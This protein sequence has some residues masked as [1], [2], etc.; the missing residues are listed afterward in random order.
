MLFVSTLVI[1]LLLSLSIAST[2]STSTVGRGENGG[3]TCAA[4]A[5]LVGLAEQLTEI[6]NE[7]IADSLAR[8]CSYLPFGFQE[9][10]KGLVEE[11]GPGI[12]ALIEKKET[13]DIACYGVGLCKHDTPQMCH[14]FPLPGVHSMQDQK[15]RILSAIK[16]AEGAKGRPFISIS[17][18]LCNIKILKPICDL[19]E[20]FSDKHDPLFDID[21]DLFSDVDSFR[22]TSW[23]GKDCN[24]AN[25][26][27]Y[28]GRRST[29]DPIYDSNCNGIFGI[30]PETSKTYEDQWCNGTSQLGVV[31]LGDSAGAHFHIPPEYLISKDLNVETFS[32]L[33]FILENEFDWPMLSMTTGY[34]NTS[35]WK[36]SISGP[37]DS[38]YLRFLQRNR[39]NHRDYQNIAVN[40]ARSSSMNRTIMRSLSRWQNLDYPVFII[41]ELIG[42]DVCSGHQDTSHMTTAQ[43]MHDNYL[44][45]FNYMDTVLPKESV[46]FA[47]GLVDGRILYDSLHNRIHPIGSLRG[48]VTYAQLYNYLNCL[49]ISPCF[50]WMNSN[51]TWR[52]ITTERAMEL[53][54]V[55]KDLISN[56]TT[57]KNIKVHYM[58]FPT[59]EVFDRWQA[60]GGKMW[61]L[62]EPVDG[63]HPNQQSNA[64]TAAVVWENLNKLYPEVI[65][66]IN[67]FNDLIVKKFGD[68]GGY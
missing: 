25:A 67:P 11:F 36:K 28:P 37:T 2:G 60:E 52:N 45:I 17:A 16:I 63:F 59:T 32:D 66:P 47:F 40:G 10:C 39:C 24:D 13:P 12:I 9:A 56:A 55:L 41:L 5:I 42:N 58:D 4:C 65:P 15:M 57:Y 48:D 34:D 19:I 46:I 7:S 29:G 62:I 68:Q 33:P 26:K 3:T 6:Y 61:E 18:D 44:A 1:S 43:E 20:R 64:L 22:G 53:S 30:D 35:E 27:V 50:G 31:V 54:K 38:L 51:E 21:G 49:Q 14:I 23:R 8:F